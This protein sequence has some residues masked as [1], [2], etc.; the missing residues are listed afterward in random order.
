MITKAVKD[1]SIA[2]INHNK[3]EEKFWN[4]LIII[5]FTNIKWDS[6]NK[7]N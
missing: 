4:L 1:S 6:T 3:Y 2:I 5:F 7:T